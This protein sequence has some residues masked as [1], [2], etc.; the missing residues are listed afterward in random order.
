MGRKITVSINYFMKISISQIKNFLLLLL[1]FVL[2]WQTRL[3]YQTAYIGSDFWEYGSLSL[4]GTE[5]LLGITILLFLIE[6][7]RGNFRE[8]FVK[9]LDKK[10]LA[11]IL[12][13]FFGGLLLYWLTSSN[14]AITW[15]YLNWS[16]YGICLIFVILES[17]LSFKKI[18]L[19]V[20]GGGLLQAMLGISQFFN[21]YVFANKW[22]GM[23]TQ[24]P[25]QLGVAV[26]E[27]GDER[28][29]R[30]Y[31]AFG[32][33]NSLG[34]YLAAIFILGV[35][36]LCHSRENGNLEGKV[37][38]SFHGNDQLW[39]LIGQVIIVAGLF[40]SLARGAWLAVMAG[41]LVLGF[42]KYKEKFFWQQIAIYAF[43]FLILLII[44]KP[45]VFSRLDWNN[46]LEKMSL[47][48]RATQW[49]EFQQVLAKNYLVGSGPGNYTT[50]LRDLYPKYFVGDLKPV[51]NI[52]LL[53]IA[54]WGLIGLILMSTLL[55]YI[56]KKLEWSFAPLIAVLVAGLFD[57][58]NVSTFTGLMFF[59]LMVGL[60]IKDSDID[61]K[62][63]RE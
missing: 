39:L 59:C 3:I 46:R 30:A 14:R 31:G 57:H 26:V 36:L 10:R 63:S 55:F 19:A 9:H 11:K 7:I 6:K 54:E 12:I 34:I 27:F 28:W 38:S 2:P 62:V 20:W 22:L 35:I 33:P 18:A 1:L 24:D 50:V 45:L 58:W 44:F 60:A 42:K 23:A 25:H 51:H 4:Y 43:T 29:L 21:Q 32:W 17:Q 61:T 53:F 8:L 47:S 13:G 5:I 56:D 40:F 48:Q 37:D 15:Q 49:T 52:Y 16:I 41:L